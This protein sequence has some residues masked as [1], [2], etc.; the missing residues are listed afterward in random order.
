MHFFWQFIFKKT[1]KQF[2]QLKRETNKNIPS[3]T[4]VPVV[5]TEE[6]KTANQSIC[7]ADGTVVKNNL[8][9]RLR[10]WV[11]THQSIVR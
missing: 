11:E 8:M 3:K 5:S 6:K 10:D 7:F 1:Q 2:Q 9:Y 4:K